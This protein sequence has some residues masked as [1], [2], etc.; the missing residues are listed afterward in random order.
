MTQMV[1][2]LSRLRVPWP[3]VR[4]ATVLVAAMVQVVPLFCAS[5]MI[6]VNFQYA[7][8]GQLA[9]SETAGLLATA[10]WQN[11]DVG[12]LGNLTRTPSSPKPLLLGDGS[13]SGTTLATSLGS[14]Q[15]ESPTGCVNRW[16]VGWLWLGMA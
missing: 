15:H 9:A 5:P 12:N 6:A 10:G 1:A 14:A 16:S 3:A 4:L 7:A 8:A 2:Q 11:V 13:L